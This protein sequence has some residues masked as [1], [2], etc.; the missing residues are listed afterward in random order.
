MSTAKEKTPTPAHRLPDSGGRKA[1]LL[2]A[3]LLLF[4]LPLMGGTYW[5]YLQS[6]NEVEKREL[7]DDLVRARTLAAMVD[8]N[9]TSAETILTSIA[10]RSALRRDWARRDLPSINSQLQEARK[11][12]PAFLFASAYDTDGT[13]RA[14]VPSDPIVG[15]NFA[16]RDWYRGVAAHWQPYVSEVYRTAAGSNPLVVAVA[17]PIRDD[18]GNPAGIL[19]ATYSLAQLAAKFTAIEQGGW[20]G[21][22]I[23]DQHGVV[24]ASPE[25]QSQSGPVSIAAYGLVGRA[26][27]G[28]E[29]SDKAAIDGQNRF[30]GFAPIP[31][32]G[33]AA[34]YERP[35]SQALT[36]AAHLHNQFR[37]MTIYLLLI[38]LAT[39]AFAAL[40][41]RRQ[42]RLLARNQALNRDLEEKIAEASRAREELDNHFNLSIDLLC[43][44]GA[45]GYFKRINPAWEK[46]LGWTTQEILAK[47]Y[48]DFIHPDD[49]E[50]TS[51]EGEI[52]SHGGTVIEFEN[53]YRCKDGSYR[54][55]MWNA[56]PLVNGQIYAMARDVTERKAT[57]EALVRAK[58][59]AERS[60]KF[61]DQFLSTM[62]HELRTPLNA[63][64]GFSDLLGEE[65][66]GPI[67]DRQRRYLNHIHS[68]G[69]HLL[70]LINDILDLSKIEAGRLQLALETVRLDTTFAEAID[71][72][73]PLAG[74]KSQTL[75]KHPAPDLSVRADSTR[76]K[77]ILMNLLG[78]AIKFTPQGG[79]IELAAKAVGDSVRIE[80][81]DSGPG[82]PPEEQK[83]IFDAFYR[84]S[85]TD[86]AVEGTGLG[87]AITQ[88][89]VELHGGKLGLESEPGSGSAFYF[90]LPLVP[91]CVGRDQ[92][93]ASKSGASQAPRILVVEDDRASATLLETQ[94]VSSGY[95]V[96]LCDNPKFAVDVAAKL[97]PAAV[98]IDIIMKPIN[99]WEVL[100]NL[101]S[102]PR[103]ARIPVIVVS[104]VD[105]KP[106]G[107]LLGADEYIVKPVE[108]PVL[109]SAVERCV[110]R[111]GTPEKH[112]I[113]VIED[114]A[115]TREF[116]AESL[117]QRGYFVD[118]AADGEEARARVAQS[119]PELIILD[120]ILPKVS[121]FQL[122]AEWRVG[123]RTADLP[124]F[125]L[126]SKDLTPD[127]KL[128]LEANSSVLLY[129][130]EQWQEAL[131]KQ[132]QRVVDPVLVGKA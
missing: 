78:N 76:L 89:L 87:L 72:L 75:V 104:I 16:Y 102:D 47:P 55:L 86:Q 100:T 111:S 66:Y 64:L 114:H 67:N 49:R 83:R 52:Q 84:I 116:I 68:G 115:P 17:V 71:T 92:K 48:L 56:T 11:F 62:S 65:R 29:G 122:L 131:F 33:W 74:P 24:A 105:Q 97:Q 30:V 39:A 1:W 106:T 36:P 90:T 119:L 46:V 27:A 23:V 127:E 99:G 6:A 32:L 103:T 22:V 53:R 35:V 129:K 19:M 21:F 38:Y 112:S 5:M 43:I 123:S 10:D 12:E 42:T 41:M 13:L 132:L 34:L 126:T 37:S 63:V 80:V 9:L 93:S 118:T 81:R 98:T 44:A 59:E 113:L 14:I 15:Q 8:Q 120:L 108:K 40:L 2:V 121:G 4:A 61:K 101:K 130:Q 60:N 31:R 107:A 73:I 109:L 3:L 50:A 128:Y 124:V 88:R 96:T 91:S 69:K 85:R 28:A 57:R 7:Q 26:L 58:E 51:K 18:Q 94:L 25:I 110:Q 70:R 125:I 117:L 77:Q 20:E 45:D 79:K 82:I 95:D 54:W